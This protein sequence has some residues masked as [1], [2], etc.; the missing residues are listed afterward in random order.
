MYMLGAN[1]YVIKLNVKINTTVDTKNLLNDKKQSD[2]ALNL[3][4]FLKKW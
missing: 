2:L 3:S 1:N 4:A